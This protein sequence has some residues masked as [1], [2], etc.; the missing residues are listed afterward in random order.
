VVLPREERDRDLCAIVFLGA[1]SLPYFAAHFR[2]AGYL[3][4]AYPFI[5]VI[6]ASVI[7]SLLSGRRALARAGGAAVLA[8]RLLGGL[9]EAGT[10]LRNGGIDTLVTDK[11]GNTRMR[12][13]PAADI[14][15][16]LGDLRAGG[17]RFVQ[18]SASFQYP[19]IFESGG[20]IRASAALFGWNRRLFPDLEIPPDAG[21]SAMTL[22]FETGMP[23]R[24]FVELPGPGDAVG[25]FS[26]RRFGSLTVVRSAPAR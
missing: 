23:V 26:E 2:V 14:E 4:G 13:I 11:A 7:G 12:R 18:A 21:A 17:V 15:G 5:A 10:F 1:C 16:M 24:R 25:R 3:I 19:I 20:S 9:Y 22:V 6:L 8:I